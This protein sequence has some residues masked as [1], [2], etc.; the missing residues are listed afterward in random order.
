MK[1]IREWTRWRAAGVCYRSL[2]SISYLYPSTK[3]LPCIV[4]NRYSSTTPTF[5]L[6]AQSKRRHPKHGK[7]NEAPSIYQTARIARY[8]LVPRGELKMLLPICK[9]FKSS[10]LSYLKVIVP[11]ISAKSQ[12][13]WIFFLAVQRP[14]SVTSLFVPPFLSPTSVH[15]DS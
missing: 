4:H 8:L 13:P 10:T 6:V 14:T 2:P 3:V 7:I 11:N 1:T 12:N 9:L 5:C 15:F